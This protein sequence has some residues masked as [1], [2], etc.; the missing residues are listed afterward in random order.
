VINLV[1]RLGLL[2]ETENQS[3]TALS[4]ED[5]AILEEYVRNRTGFAER[6]PTNKAEH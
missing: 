5:H 1:T 6:K 3:F 2:S 4:E